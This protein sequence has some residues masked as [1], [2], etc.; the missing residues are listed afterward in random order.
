MN[1]MMSLKQLVVETEEFF[2][3][4]GKTMQYKYYIMMYTRYSF[5][6]TVILLSFAGIVL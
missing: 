4:N 1:W 2:L 3:L 5:P 6:F